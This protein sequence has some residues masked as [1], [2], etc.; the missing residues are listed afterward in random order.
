[1]LGD[2]FP[3]PPQGSLLSNMRDL[4]HGTEDKSILANKYYDKK[5]PRTKR[6]FPSSGGNMLKK[7]KMR[8]IRIGK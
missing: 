3:N 4:M 7:I 5:T 2:S 8:G 6:L 1:M